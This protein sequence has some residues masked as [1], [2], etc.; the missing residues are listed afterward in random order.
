MDN[1]DSLNLSDDKIFFGSEEET[2]K[3]QN[4]HKEEAEYI[5]TEI[6]EDLERTKIKLTAQLCLSCICE[7]ARE[8]GDTSWR[9]KLYFD[10]RVDFLKKN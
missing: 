4:C 10:F 6:W 9:E 2:M 7:K 8:I 5:V 1:L 3:C